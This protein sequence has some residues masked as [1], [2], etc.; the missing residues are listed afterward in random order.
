MKVYYK[1]D[2]I[3][4][5]T[6]NFKD[7]ADG[8]SGTDIEY[9]SETTFDDTCAI[10]ASK[11]GHK[12]VL[13]LKTAGA[14]TIN[15]I[16][17]SSAQ[18][19]GTIELHLYNAIADD[20]YFRMRSNAANYPISIRCISKTVLRIYSGDGV[21]G[22]NETNV[23]I[24]EDE[25]FH[26]KITFNCGTDKFSCWVNGILEV[27]DQNFALDITCDNLIFDNIY[28]A[29]A[30]ELYIDAIGYSWDANYNVGDNKH[31]I[32][33]YYSR[34]QLT[35]I[36]QYPTIIPRNN[37][38]CLCSVVLRDF[39]GALF[40]TWH[41]NDYS[42]FV[43]EDNDENKL[44]RG[45]LINKKFG[46]KQLELFLAGLGV[47]LDWMPFYRDYVLQ[48]GKVKTVPAT[49]TLTMYDDK[50]ES[51][52]WDAGEDFTWAVDRWIFDQSV[53]LLL[54][55]STKTIDVKTWECSAISQ[56]NGTNTGGN[57]GSLDDPNDDDTYD[58][59]ESTPDWDAYITPVMTAAG[60]DEVATTKI[61]NK[62]VIN[63]QFHYKG[64]V[65]L[66]ETARLQLK[67][68][69]SD[70]EWTPIRGKDMV[71]NLTYYKTV[72]GSFPIVMAS[73]DLAKF[74]TTDNG[75]WDECLELRLEFVYGETNATAYIKLDYL[76][77]EV[78]YEAYVIQ[79]IMAAITDSA[80]S[81]LT[82]SSIAKWDETGLSVNDDFK[83][84][85]N[86]VQIVDDIGTAAGLGIDVLGLDISGGG[87]ATLRPNGDDSVGWG[88]TDSGGDGSHWKDLDEV[89][90]Q[91]NAGDENTIYSSTEGATDIFTMGTHAMG[92]NEVVKKIELWTYGQL[93]SALNIG[94]ASF[95][96]TS[97][98]WSEDRFPFKGIE[99]GS[100]HWIKV[101]W[102]NLSLSQADL[103]SLKMKFVYS[104][105]FAPVSYA[106]VDLFYVVITYGL[107]NPFTKF[108]AR[109]FR[110]T[111]CI[112]ALEAVCEL[113][114]AVWYEDYENNRI[115]VLKPSV[116]ESSDV[117]ITEALRKGL[118]YEDICN[119]VRRVDV[120]GSVENVDYPIHEYS[121][122]KTVSG[123][124][125]RQIIN[126]RIMTSGD[127]KEIADAQLA[128]LN[129]KRP[130]IRIPLIGTY[131][132][133]QLGRTIRITMVRPTIAVEDYPI[134]M[135]ERSKFGKTGIKTVVYC[136]LGETPDDEK[137]GMAIR[138]IGLLTNRSMSDR[139]I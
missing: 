106:R 118:E 126:E 4:P 103:D 109:K 110:G 29:D 92:A 84:G 24:V 116:F 34:T 98:G 38:H 72:E 82:C 27:D 49:S 33:H 3:Y 136:G 95:H 67:I 68:R 122:D 99:W 108:I 52:A 11:G 50:N 112:D 86:T 60:G 138:K 62:I 113:E 127:A 76:T 133:L 78:H 107:Y 94:Q 42:E 28:T 79:P 129:T 128:R 13:Y 59:N 31:D 130:S 93:D 12:K 71:G 65:L 124:R 64:S 89:V 14:G 23:T 115:V 120:F 91:P 102:D 43:I 7:E 134:R 40:D 74:L 41:G 87:T 45:Y 96:T 54:I 20:F 132:N 22:N 48:E 37:M 66:G 32:Y 30:A 51:G 18:T 73:S 55:D 77:I 61:L 137:I 121:E 75:N 53:G 100:Y 69:N 25:F 70:N 39:E 26:V 10:V 123:F 2:D 15:G 47:K 85:Q 80:A 135:I 9:V 139:L 90:V 114:G 36:I 1:E 119:Q 83:I 17:Y 44:F 111:H 56:T 46:Y 131:P 58:V 5:A 81:T 57:A 117:V 19:A 125:C 101:S 63:Y 35:D 16:A 88:H 104:E 21:G 6:Y 105:V 97:T 8:T